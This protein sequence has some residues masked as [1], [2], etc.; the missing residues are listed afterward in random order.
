MK[1]FGEIGVLADDGERVQCHVCGKWY[2]CLGSHIV[3]TH[4]MSC[5]DYK[6]QFGLCKRVGLAS[7]SL[8]AVI[9]EQHGERMTDIARERGWP[10][11]RAMT[12]QQRQDISTGAVR[13]ESTRLALKRARSMES[14]GTK[15][16]RHTGIVASHRTPE[17]RD[18]ARQNVVNG[19]SPLLRPDIQAKARAATRT[20]EAKKKR[21]DALMGRIVTKET[22][23]KQSDS[24][25]KLLANPEAKAAFIKQMKESVTPE[26]KAKQS[27]AKKNL[28]ADPDEKAAFVKRMKEAQAAKRQNN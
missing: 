25:K 4:G 24:K 22:R 9:R 2:R 15:S 26:T 11:V 1:V 10:R 17:Y 20:S 27:A 13:R 19:V 8:R 21:S 5:D 6:V 3:K 18:K 16:A 12:K 28:F 14:A 7:E 23:Q